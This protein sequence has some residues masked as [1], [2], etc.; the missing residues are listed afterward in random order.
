MELARL[1]KR[2][3]AAHAKG[4]FESLGP[5]YIKRFWAVLRDKSRMDK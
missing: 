3:S 5:V 4:L 2:I 1:M